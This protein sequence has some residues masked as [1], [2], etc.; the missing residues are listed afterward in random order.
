MDD[1]LI[2]TIFTCL[3]NGILAALPKSEKK[4]LSIR[5]LGE[6]LDMPQTS[7]YRIFRPLM[8]WDNIG[9]VVKPRRDR[10]GAHEKFF[11]LKHD[12]KIH[13][14]NSSLVFEYDYQ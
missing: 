1:K 13:F 9:I 6:V 10:A 4:A 5:E 3:R 8:K 11:Y 7:M 2:Y 12:F 14:K